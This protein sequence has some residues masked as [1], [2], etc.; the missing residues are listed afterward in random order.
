MLGMA[1]RLRRSRL[2][3]EGARYRW[4]RDEYVEF[5]QRQRRDLFLSI[6]RYHHINRPMPGYYF[7]FGSH[8]ANT[9]RMAWDSFRHLFDRLYV[10]FDSFEGLPEIPED[11]RQ[12]IWQAGKL[13]TD[14]DE[15]I[16]TC[17][18]HGM[19]RDRLITVKGF[20]RNTLTDELQERLLPNPAAVVYVD[21][22]LY[23]ST[24]PVLRF[25][26]PFLQ[27]GTVV[28]FDDWVAFHGDPDK[29][30]QRAW[31]EFRAARPDLRFVEFVRTAEANSFVFL[32]RD[33]DAPQ[34]GGTGQA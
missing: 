34:A 17:L 30:E 33:G 12:E 10:A 31:A 19:R 25:I 5:G 4:I 2:H 23:S 26:D 28:V 16:H 32:G 27:R 6:A 7:E 22:D 8:G 1:D 21:C 13:R 14:E 20:Y 15:F 3:P 11:E 18:E 24:R 9:M 29:G